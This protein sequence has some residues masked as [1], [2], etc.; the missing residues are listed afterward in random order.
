MIT[1]QAPARLALLSLAASAVIA[2]LIGWVQA[3]DRV[4]EDSP[5]WPRSERLEK[6]MALRRA[7]A[8]FQ[9]AL[10]GEVVEGRL[11]LGEAAR[12]LARY[13]AGEPQVEGAPSGGDLMRLFPG[14]TEEEQCAC[15][16]VHWAHGRAGGTQ[17]SE[18][19]RRTLPRLE[20]ELAEAYGADLPGLLSRLRRAML[21]LAPY[22]A[23][24]AGGGG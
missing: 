5:E 10:V 19:A 4:P 17:P 20:H 14:R 11:P 16:L 8:E 9:A 2:L 18:A 24:A 21:C 12:R 22:E 1:P 23:S 7:R 6:G 15:F 3:G 13:H